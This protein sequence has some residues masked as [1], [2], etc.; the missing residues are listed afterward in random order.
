MREEHKAHRWQN[1]KQNI[2]QSFQTIRIDKSSD[3]DIGCSHPA[4]LFMQAADKTIDLDYF[5]RSLLLIDKRLDKLLDKRRD[6]RRDNTELSRNHN[7][8]VSPING[9]ED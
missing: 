8:K 7:S 2:E 6:K 3:P 5:I 1:I 9:K 4:S